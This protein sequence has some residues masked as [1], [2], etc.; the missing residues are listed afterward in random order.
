MKYVLYCA[1]RTDLQCR[2]SLKSGWFRGLQ[3]L[4][5]FVIEYTQIEQL[6]RE[7]ELYGM[8]WHTC[9]NFL[10]T[11]PLWMDGPFQEI[12]GEQMVQNMDKW[13]RSAAT[14]AKMLTN[15]EPKIVAEELKR[16][17]EAFQVTN[18]L[19]SIILC[20]VCLSELTVVA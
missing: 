1:K 14:C 5:L 9:N 2:F 12:D 6:E 7:F 11:N 10:R 3:I 20:P 17:I 4:G 16:R 8:L 13:F 15:V 19:Q 18:Q